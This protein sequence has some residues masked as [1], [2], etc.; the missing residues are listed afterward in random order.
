MIHTLQKS[1]E[2]KEGMLS[3]ANEELAQY[4]SRI[5][6][7]MRNTMSNGQLATQLNEKLKLKELAIE[8]LKV[9]IAQREERSHQLESRII[10]DEQ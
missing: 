2:Q 5:N 9:K 7:E 10:A 4:N 6:E 8:D 1:L 3:K